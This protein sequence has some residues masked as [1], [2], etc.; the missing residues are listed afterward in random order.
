[1]ESG[2]SRPGAFIDK[3]Y[4]NTSFR[5]AYFGFCCGDT[6]ILPHPISICWWKILTLNV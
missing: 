6:D 4:K 5:N 1:M 3:L 2:F